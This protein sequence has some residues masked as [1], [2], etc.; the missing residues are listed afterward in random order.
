MKV[1]KFGGASV[2]DA[3]SVK[4]MSNILRHFDDQDLVVVVSAMG[5]STNHLEKIIHVGSNNERNLLIQSFLAYH[6]KISYDL[7][8]NAEWIE[9][10]LEVLRMSLYN[11]LAQTGES[12]V[13]YSPVIAH[14]EMISSRI[15]SQ[16]LQSIGMDF[17]W[18]DSTKL[19]KTDERDREARINWELTEKNINGLYENSEIKRFITQGFIGSD[20]DGRI[21]TLGREG[22]DYT[23]AI[24]SYCL[25]AESMTV[26]KDVPGIMSADPKIIKGSVCFDQLNYQEAAEMTYY[27]VKAIHPKTI[28]PLAVKNIPLLVKSFINP[29]YPGTKIHSLEAE[30]HG[31]AIIFK[32]DQCLITFVVKDFTFIN[33]HHISAI[34]R[35]LD[36]LR[37][38]FNLMQNS[39]ISFSICV[40]NDPEKNE[41]L[42]TDLKGEFKVNI[43]NDLELIT[44]KNYDLNTVNLISKGKKIILEQRTLENYQIVVEGNLEKPVQDTLD[45]AKI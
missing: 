23:A 26:W 27:G 28:R 30:P 8:L 15:I 33:E 12:G 35:K 3:E 45:T 20:E 9:Q 41:S 7:Q 6:E 13:Y 19:I 21:T 31:P 4:N 43:L 22:S 32:F 36:D 37:I 39:A 10:T 40:N 25:N 34:F 42:I 2:K 16:Y 14:G 38:T 24:Y 1:F 17:Q 11:A 18:L 44:V 29:D 5:K